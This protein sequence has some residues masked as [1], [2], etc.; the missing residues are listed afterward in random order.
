MPSPASPSDATAAP[1]FSVRYPWPRPA[2]AESDPVWRDGAFYLEGQAPVRVLSYT[3]RESNWSAELTDLHEEAGGTQHP[4][5]VASRRLASESARR[6]VDA[7]PAAAGRTPVIMDAGCSS[8]YEIDDLRRAAP[9]AAIFGSDFI[10][11]PLV[12]LGNRMPD[13]P[14]IQM[15]L[16]HCPLP[17][18][19]LDGVVSLNVLEHIDDDVKAL[20]QIY[21]VLR[22]GALA[23]IEVPA[24]PFLYDEY[25]RH[26]MHHR[27]Y[28]RRDLLG[29]A[30][31]QGFEVV[32]STHLGFFVFPGFAAVKGLGLWRGGNKAGAEAG[33]DASHVVERD[34]RNTRDSVLV[35][36]ALGLEL[37]VGRI[38][39][40][41][42]GIRCVAVFRKPA[43]A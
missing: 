3:T 37:A 25:D 42:I 20:G 30:R 38:F 10:L 15:D 11:P 7:V 34:I 18:N 16:R 36:W 5:D 27:R 19:S 14:L 4:I 8:G 33:K 31:S 22:P 6:M 40:Y 32:S 9:R 35:R 26:L 21:R 12:G 2:G 24:C 41:P 28:T 17:S 29:K 43:A 13:L 23:H 39:S 1:G